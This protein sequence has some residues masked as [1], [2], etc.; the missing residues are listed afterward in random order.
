MDLALITVTNF[1]RNDIMKKNYCKLL[2]DTVSHIKLQSTYIN[3]DLTLYN[4]VNNSCFDALHLILNPQICQ[5][6]D[7]NP[8][9]HA[10]KKLVEHIKREAS[11]KRG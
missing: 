5:N 10:I 8:S 1:V 2:L 4:F 7:S 11:R 3:F 9:E 6:Y